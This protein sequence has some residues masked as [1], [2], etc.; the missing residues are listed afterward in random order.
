MLI[1]LEHLLGRINLP[2]IW[3]IISERWLCC[4]TPQSRCTFCAAAFLLRGTAWNSSP[5]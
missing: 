5:G 1:V 3:W 2:G 4:D